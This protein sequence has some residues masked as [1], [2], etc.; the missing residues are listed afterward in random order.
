MNK[1][2]SLLL[3]FYCARRLAPAPS[4]DSER[5]GWLALTDRFNFPNFVFLLP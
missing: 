3:A 1:A 4:G 5:P 2:F